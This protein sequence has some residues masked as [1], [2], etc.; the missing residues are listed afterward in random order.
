MLP[1]FFENR[2]TV[3]PGYGPAA[4]QVAVE[5]DIL[6]VQRL[7]QIKFPAVAFHH[8]GCEFGVQ[9]IHLAGLTRRQM[10]NQKRN[11]GYKK[12]GNAF[13]NG[14]AG[15]ESYHTACPYRVI[16]EIGINY[17]IFVKTILIEK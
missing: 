2:L 12:E 8:F 6:P 17:R 1:Y 9:G 15:D 14:A 13:L 7:V 16:L 4:K 11:H 10:D 5:I 3:L